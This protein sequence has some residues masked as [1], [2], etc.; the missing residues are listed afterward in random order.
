[1]DNNL[2]KAAT[3]ARDHLDGK[4]PSLVLRF[5]TSP[6]RPSETQAA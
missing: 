5:V 3:V 6:Q 4:N 1:M 2:N